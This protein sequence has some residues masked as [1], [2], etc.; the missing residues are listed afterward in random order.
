MYYLLGSFPKYISGATCDLI[1]C[2]CTIDST[3]HECFDV[4]NFLIFGK[5]LFCVMISYNALCKVGILRLNEC[6]YSVSSQT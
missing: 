5:P 4:F 1:N 2:L 6:T 3:L